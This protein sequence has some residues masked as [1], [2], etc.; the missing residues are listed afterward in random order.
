MQSAVGAHAE[1]GRMKMEVLA[2]IRHTGPHA[3]SRCYMCT[4]ANVDV[5]IPFQGFLDRWQRFKSETNG[6][7]VATI[8]ERLTL[9]L[10]EH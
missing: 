1:N 6:S 9:S 5:V 7:Y 10:K 8:T 2:V 3:G 4:E